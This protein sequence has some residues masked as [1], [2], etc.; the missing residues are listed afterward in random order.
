MQAWIF[1]SEYC[2]SWLAR[3]E[4]SL[5]V[6][7]DHVVGL[8]DCQSVKLIFAALDEEMIGSRGHTHTGMT[9]GSRYAGSQAQD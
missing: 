1:T 6:A 2:V 3:D 8:H 7:H 9:E 4:E 5:G